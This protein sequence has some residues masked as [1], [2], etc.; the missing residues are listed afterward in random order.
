MSLQGKYEL[1]HSLGLLGFPFTLSSLN[2]GPT[3]TTSFWIILLALK[4][5]VRHMT[6]SRDR[7]KELGRFLESAAIKEI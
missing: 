6:R 7:I 4:I 3:I 1:G 5:V 2:N